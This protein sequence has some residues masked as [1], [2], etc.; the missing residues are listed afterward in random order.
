MR[1]HSNPTQDNHDFF[2]L[3]PGH[4]FT[5]LSPLKNWVDLVLYN[6]D[7]RLCS[8]F[9]LQIHDD[10]CDEKNVN[11]ERSPFQN[12]KIFTTIEVL[13]FL[14]GELQWF[15]K[16]EKQTCGNRVPKFYKYQEQTCSSTFNMI[17]KRQNYNTTHTINCDTDNKRVSIYDALEANVITLGH[18]WNYNKQHYP[19][20]KHQWDKTV[21][22]SNSLK[23]LTESHFH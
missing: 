9:K 16:N 6:D 5:R 21:F 17:L 10:E 3:H 8:I 19:N 18:D 1:V 13:G 14:F 12:L 20:I 4:H 22:I 7:A 23:F 15:T 11:R 2:S